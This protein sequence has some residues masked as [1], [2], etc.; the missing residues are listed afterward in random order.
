MKKKIRYSKSSAFYSAAKQDFFEKNGTLLKRAL[1]LNALYADQPRREVCKLCNTK[2]TA[3]VDFHSHGIDYVFCSSCSHLNG[4]NED[5]KEFISM[6]YMDDGGGD[7]ALNYLDE[8]FEDRVTNIYLPKAEFLEEHM[9]RSHFT[10]LDVGCGAGYFV[11]ACQIRGI[12]AQGLDVSETMVNF[13]NGQ[14]QH[15]TGEQNSLAIT[16]EEDFYRSV[17][18]TSADTIS[19]I[20]VIEHLRSP[21]LLFD[22]FKRSNAKYLYFSVPMFSLSAVL[23]N[24][25]PMVFPRQL[26]GAHT[27]LFTE[28]SIKELYS[29]MS[30]EP[31]AEWRFGTD[32]QDLFRALMIMFEKNGASNKACEIVSGEIT[33]L[34]DKL[35][36]V[37]DE[38]HFCSEIHGLVRKI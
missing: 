27:H 22:A 8:N 16:S 14:L 5:T 7:Y 24:A 30:V 35:Q 36:R 6:L 11:G 31:V 15:L 12:S 17:V 20:G 19:A 18:E 4:V 37:L 1:D 38:A 26:S 32:V 34:N 23:E 10:L 9:P 28:G 2:L 3:E 13:G 25:M 33:G 29:Q 21:H